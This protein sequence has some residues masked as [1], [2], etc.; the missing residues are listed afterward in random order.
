M[1]LGIQ[2]VFFVLFFRGVFLGANGN[3]FIKT[4]LKARRR[5][6]GWQIFRRRAR[7]KALFTK[8]REFFHLFLQVWSQL[9]SLGVREGNLP[10][11][12]SRVLKPD[13]QDLSL[14]FR[15]KWYV[16]GTF[17]SWHPSTG[18]CSGHERQAESRRSS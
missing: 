13:L 8:S 12:V 17:C 16:N 11:R 18:C 4:K 2:V 14:G 7:S 15:V 6:L 5:I 10:L 1:P 3:I 9:L